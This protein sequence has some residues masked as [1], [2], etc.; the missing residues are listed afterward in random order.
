MKKCPY[1]FT[2]LDDRASICSNCRK[3][4]GKKS[5]NGIAK[6]YTSP[7]TK[8][9]LFIFIIGLVPMILVQFSSFD[10][11]EKD[12]TDV[13]IKRVA[14]G[15]TRTNLTMAEISA[16]LH[17]TKRGYVAATTEPILSKAINILASGDTDAFNKF[18]ND[19]PNV[20]PLKGRH[21]GISGKSKVKWAHKNQTT[22]FCCFSLDN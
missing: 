13:N 20:F 19:N 22:R 9:I 8:F 18:S 6:K 14:T 21:K 15:E 7:V 16:G 5:R 17:I 12:N 3:K 11:Y 2:E 10:N 1:C 4:V